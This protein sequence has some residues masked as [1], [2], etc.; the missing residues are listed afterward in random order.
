M[1]R[2]FALAAAVLL[3]ALLTAPVNAATSSD[4]GSLT[5][6]GG[7]QGQ[8]KQTPKAA[9]SWQ[10]QDKKRRAARKKALAMKQ[11]QLSKTA[12]SKKDRP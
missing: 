10:E 9:K 8:I 1:N 4:V 11:K 7:K 2:I 12:E 5:Q 6:Q 3:S